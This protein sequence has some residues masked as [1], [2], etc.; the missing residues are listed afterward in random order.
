MKNQ[1]PKQITERL[2]AILRRV[3]RIQF[4]RGMLG[5][6]TLSL[7]AILVIIAADYFFAP[8]STMVR[9]VLFVGLI[10]VA[11][12][13]FW[14]LL[15]KPLSRKIELLQIARWLEVRH[16]EMQERISTAL[17]LAGKSGTGVSTDLIEELINEAE[18][19]AKSLDPEIEVQSRKARV[20]L[21]PALGIAAT[22]MLLFAIWPAQF[23]RLLARAVAP[24]SE[25]GNAGAVAFDIAPG[26]LEVLED[27]SLEIR[28]LYQGSKNDILTLETTN[29]NGDVTQERLS[30]SGEEDGKKSH[31]TSSP[32]LARVSATE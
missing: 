25:L 30:F 3:R 21:V 4:F 14:K 29:E 18:L 10:L 6:L 20:W 9:W 32:Q 16:P 19:D 2:E 13:S 12:T 7:S 26:N 31:F 23:G 24:F 1:L 27:D 17:E 15:L 28:V 22:F 11:V 5:V 8:L